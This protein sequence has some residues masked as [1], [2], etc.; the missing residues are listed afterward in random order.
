[1]CHHV[2]FYDFSR[3]KCGLCREAQ[4]AIVGGCRDDYDGPE[5][6]FQHAIVIW[7]Q[8]S[9]TLTR[10]L[11]VKLLRLRAHWRD[12]HAPL[13]YW[14]DTPNS[15]YVIANTFNLCVVLIAR[16]G[17][18]TVLLLYSYLDRTAVTNTRWI[19]IALL[20]VQWKYHRSDRV[21]GWA[22]AYSD[23]IADWNTR[24]ARAYPP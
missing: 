13:E 22:E 6:I 15:L 24:Y 5:A 9:L 20:H 12:G 3:T 1:M 4:Y 11:N 17:S 18:T 21:S 14:L 10:S 2:I 8:C 16:F 23:R 7:A 19:P